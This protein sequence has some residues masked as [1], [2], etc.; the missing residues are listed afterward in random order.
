MWDSDAQ[1]ESDG[2]QL[3]RKRSRIEEDNRKPGA[4]ISDVTSGQLV[5]MRGNYTLGKN[6]L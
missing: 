6:Y 2:S 3:T 1:E 5:E 4:D